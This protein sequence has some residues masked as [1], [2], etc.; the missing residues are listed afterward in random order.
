MA[1][2][3]VLAKQHHR[4]LSR[5]SPVPVGLLTGSVKGVERR[6]RAGRAG[7]GRLP[8]VVG[9]HALFQEAV[10]YRDLGWR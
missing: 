2:T 5:L 4:T 9:T 7:D 10:E 1:P 8:L 6:R 3:E